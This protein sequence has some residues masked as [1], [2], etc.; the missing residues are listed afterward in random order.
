[1]VFYI[2]GLGLSDETDITYKGLQAVKSC[3]IIYLEHYT[4]ILGVQKEKLEEFYGKTITLADRET[5]EETIDEILKNC[6]ENEDKNSAVLVVGDPFCATTH[7]DM[8]LRAVKIGLKVE[9][10]HNASIM[11]AVACCGLQLYRF[12]ETVT[13]PFF[14]EN[15][16]PYSFYEKI[17]KNRES[18]LHTLVLVDI[19]VKERTDEN[20][21]KNRKIY[22][23]PR[24]MT[25]AT[26]VEEMLE[27]E[28]NIK[29]EAYNKDTLGF[30]LSRV[31]SKDQKVVAGRMEDFLERIEMGP[32][33]HS[34][35]ICAPELH[36]IEKEMFDFYK[37]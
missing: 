6:K 11:N 26:A 33:L 30:G 27:A 9:V 23:P 3:D 10:I 24:Y 20:L 29:K 2:I 22:E 19:K 32:P 21:F 1:M 37:F 34:F 31:G 25:C 16:R 17:R 4:S 15:W 14:T 35:V 36:E 8:F 5:C 12:G 28:D 18:N 13:I 7:T